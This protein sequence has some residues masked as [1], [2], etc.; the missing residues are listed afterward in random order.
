MSIHAVGGKLKEARS[1]PETGERDY[2][3]SGAA[4]QHD[5]RP[6]YSPFNTGRS[7]LQQ[8]NQH[9]SCGW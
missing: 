9:H 6:S 3:E 7:A 8:E 1:N 5:T 2:L 4:Q